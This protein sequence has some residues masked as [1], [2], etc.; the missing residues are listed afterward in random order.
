MPPACCCKR[1]MRKRLLIS[2]SALCLILSS[3]CKDPQGDPADPDKFDRVMILYCCG[4]INLSSAIKSNIDQLCEGTYVPKKGSTD[5]IL[6]FEHC[7]NGNTDFK[8]PTDCH[9]IRIYRNYMGTVVRDTVRTTSPVTNA[10]P[11]VL[12]ET[13][14]YIKLN[15]NADHYSMVMNSHGT[16][17]LEQGTYNDSGS[18]FNF[19]SVA[20]LSFAQERTTDSSGKKTDHFIDIPDLAAAI[21]MHLD[22]LI[23]DACLMGNVETVYEL[24]KVA[25]YIV[26]SP[27][28]V[29]SRGFCYNTIASRLLE[30]P[31]S[32]P[33]GVCEDYRDQ[34]SS[35]SGWFA[36]C[37][38][39]MTNTSQLNSLAAVVKRLQEKYATKVKA[40]SKTSVQVYD[41]DGAACFF[42]LED[43]YIKAGATSEEIADL[44]YAVAACVE[45]K[46]ISDTFFYIKNNHCCGL[47]M[48][49]P[50][51]LDKKTDF[52]KTLQW[53]DAV[54]LVK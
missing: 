9:L 12:Q 41:N 1:K 52:Y 20:P 50:Q 45:F 46:Y 35:E 2:L 51:Y 5:A 40:L 7:S 8:T 15:Y 30:E 54:S 39:S 22:N 27:T 3:C 48:A 10:D 18:D 11:A 26:A 33:K 25:S 19:W 17:W 31:V 13:L 53:N 37:T 14:S 32:N 23:F 21:P 29:Q 38:V 44:Q 43:I 4:Y 36:S 49:L 47:S 34:F 24:R 6:V 28:Q 42:D 16:G